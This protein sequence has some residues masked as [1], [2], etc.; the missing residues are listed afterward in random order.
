MAVGWSRGAG[1]PAQTGGAFLDRRGV[2]LSAVG[3]FTGLS[4]WAF[5]DGVWAA[6]QAPPAALAS[7][8]IAAP[9]APV[10]IVATA[11]ALAPQE[12]EEV[13]PPADTEP[14][15]SRE[16]LPDAR[17]MERL[18]ADLAADQVRGN[19][20]AAAERL[21]RIGAPSFPWLERAL[22][23][24]DEQ[25]RHFAA[26]VLRGGAA[27]ASPRL[28][29][30]SVEALRRG[31]IE[32]FGATFVVAARVIAAQ[33]LADHP[34]EARPA[35]QRAVYSADDQ[36]RFLAAFLLAQGGARDQLPYVARLLIEHLGDNSIEG[37]AVMAGH[38]LWCLGPA[39]LP[40]LRLARRW[41]DPQARTLLDRIEL[42][43]AD[44]ARRDPDPGAQARM[45]RISWAYWDPV[46]SFDIH[47]GHVPA[48]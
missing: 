15:P 19:A 4:L 7:R 48:W 33:W 8:G 27:P 22:F 37:D 10:P 26:E 1:A 3:L 24:H 2:L 43:L 11:T 12:R 5:G 47:R 25:Q 13:M 9:V 40:E 46:V 31:E 18:C 35:L 23:S 45:S 32:G 28:C 29:E 17:T 42:D 44:P 6:P 21:A 36:Q 14:P 30:V 38:G 39:V 20:L 41:A 16:P 34:E